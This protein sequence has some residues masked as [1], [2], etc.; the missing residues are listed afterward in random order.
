MGIGREVAD[1]YIS[2]HGDLTPFRKELQNANAEMQ[3]WAIENSDTFTEAFG[4]R[5]ESQMMRQW[6]SVIDMMHSGKKLD[7]NR[8]VEAFDISNI[9][10]A[11]DKIN[12]ML[13]D[14]ER[15]GKISWRQFRET[16]KAID[17]Q[18]ETIQKQATLEESLARDREKWGRAHQ[19]MMA[20]RS[21]ALKQEAAEAKNFASAQKRMWD[22][23]IQ[24]NKNYDAS[25]RERAR[26]YD[27][28]MKSMA[29]AQKK[30]LTEATRMNQ[31]FD[32]QER[33]RIKMREQIQKNFLAAERD[34]LTEAYRINKDHDARTRT[35]LQLRE[36][37]NKQIQDARSKRMEMAIRENEAWSRSFKGVADAARKADLEGRFRALGLAM[38]TG[39]WGR[40][41][42][43]AKD[44]GMLRNRT[45]AT[46][47]EMRNLGRMTVEEFDE[48]A[49]RLQLVG[50]NVD[51]YNIKFS[52]VEKKTTQHKRDWDIIGSLIGNA[53]KKFAGFTGLNV[54]T[55][56]FRQG[57]E[58]FQNLDRNAV[59]IGKMTLMA[60]TLA[61]T[62]VH[63]VGGLAVMGQ[64]LA[65]IGN[66]ALFA[67][68]F[69]TAAGIGIGVLVAA[70]K[71]MGTVLEDLGPRFEALQDSI[72]AEFWAV[73]E[74]PIRNL[75]DALLPTLET[76][77]AE[78]ATSMGGLTA[79]FADAL[80]NIDTDR[81]TG[82]FDRMNSG[83]DIAQGMMQPLVDAF[84]TLGEA[85]SMYFER[86][87][88]WLVDLSTRFNT[89]IQ[90]AAEDGRLTEWMDRAIQGIQDVG[91]AVAGIVGIF[92]AVA[93]AAEAAGIGGLSTFATAMTNASTIMNSAGFQEG[94]THLFTG[95]ADAARTVGDAIINLGPVLGTLMPII[96]GVLSTIG[97]TVATLIGYVG[98]IF[99]NPMVQAGIT[100]FF[101]GI[102]GAVAV[103]QPAITP[104]AESF[105]Q[106]LAVLG[107]VAETVGLVVSVM[108]TSLTP[109]LDT[110]TA[111]F[112]R[113]TFAA[114]PE[115]ITIM[116]TLGDVISTM[117]NTI[118]PP[119]EALIMTVLPLISA[120][121][122]ALAPIFPVIAEAIAPVIA[123]FQQLV[124]QVGPVLIPAIQQIVEAVTPVIEVFGQVVEFILSIVVP[125]LGALLIGVI[126]NLVG[127]FQGL[128]DFIMGFVAIVTA[129]FTGFGDFFQLLFEGKI[130][131]ALVR[132]Q[133]MFGQIWDGITQMVSGA[134]TAIWNAIQLWIVGKMVVGI[135]TALMGAKGFFTSIWGS[136]TS[137]LNGAVRNIQNFLTSGFQAIGTMI[138]TVWNTIM[139]V[140]KTVWGTITGSVSTSMNALANRI[141]AG[142]N[143]IKSFFQTAWNNMLNIIK[144]AWNNIKS[145]VQTGINN[146]ESFVRGLPGKI[147][148]ALG[149]LGTL[150]LGAGQAV[151]D[152]FLEGLTNAFEGVKN[153]VGGIASWIA[154]NKGPLPYDRR[155]LVP[156]GNA[157]MEG[158]GAGLEDK[159][160]MLKR[161]LDNVTDTMTNSVTDA[162]SK[163]KMY[164]A[165]ADAALGLADGLKSNKRAVAE[166]LAVVMPKTTDSS[167]GVKLA[168]P[169]RATTEGVGTPTPGKLITIE[170]LNM[171][172]NTPTKD[173]EVVASKV[174][175][176]FAATHSNL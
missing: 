144:T 154:D 32:V 35:I 174:I 7:F 110:V 6:N 38:A 160:T 75:V 150:L 100:Q 8:M 130:T 60:G 82:M 27:S 153:F 166:A 176:D 168:T 78:T 152:G 24:M 21:V 129:I 47:R 28:M 169:G 161:I 86:F 79:A 91:T 42:Q 85:G 138:R 158:L 143:S 175:D 84:T 40:I 46:A 133:I 106:V 76:K 125:I 56:M 115:I 4:D 122:A 147:T 128:S 68:G 146:V 9:E 155:L 36:K 165:G 43:G 172:I 1:A 111:L 121:F 83:I 90:G 103:L 41:S 93:T 19:A 170:T 5:M 81:I 16:T 67:P 173:P 92:N 95:A 163:S 116:Q 114:G 156:A 55:D 96:S 77:L 53:G 30:M 65:A 109:V 105:G 2:V 139:N 29:D 59:N 39:D 151:I 52:D 33:I 123:A 119:F 141:T 94:L 37:L 88:T 69:L 14:M 113:I 22:E 142:L 73:A 120:G 72:S 11:S 34:M 57:S 31:D 117:M 126:G 162:F 48:V 26:I 148:S 99:A 64:D 10:E 70:F 97:E 89:F 112:S 104:L 12:R 145:A 3:A 62:I 23:A 49:K 140:I 25:M 74:A 44:M 131:E 134:V 20:Q 87:A 80:A 15:A 51:A 54:M 167:V 61:S 45:M 66:I 71:D 18:I 171:P 101:D 132:L 118:M 98:E 17:T 149:D 58:F 159:L 107:Q 108:I 164:L 157:I 124:E 50:K 137:F 135:K 136:I 102:Q 63:A 127:V 13:V